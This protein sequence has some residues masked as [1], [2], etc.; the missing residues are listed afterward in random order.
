MGARPEDYE[1]ILPPHSYVSVDDFASPRDLAEYLQILDAN[2]TLYNEYFR[3]K[4]DWIV[5]TEKNTTTWCHMCGLIHVAIE[6]KYVNWFNDYDEYFY[7]GTC[8]PP[9]QWTREGI[10]WQRWHTQGQNSELG[11]TTRGV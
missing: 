1:A 7:K 3:W 10:H 6:T 8:Q 9:P 11:A 4:S 5:V 2:D